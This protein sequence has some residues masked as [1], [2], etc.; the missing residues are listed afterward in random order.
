LLVRTAPS[1][2]PAIAILGATN[3]GGDV[4]VGAWAPRSKHHTTSPRRGVKVSHVVVVGKDVSPPGSSSRESQ[5]VHTPGD[6]I[7]FD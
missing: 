1:S 7:S 4:L 2:R 3:Q 5:E 6:S